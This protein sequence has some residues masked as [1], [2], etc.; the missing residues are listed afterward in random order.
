MNRRAL[1]RL[2][3]L[4]IL[5]NHS[6]V[7]NFEDINILKFVLLT[8]CTYAKAIGNTLYY[9]VRITK[10]TLVCDVV[11]LKHFVIEEKQWIYFWYIYVY[12]CMKFLLKNIQIL[13]FIHE[14]KDVQLILNVFNFLNN[15]A[16]CTSED[17]YFVA[18]YADYKYLF[19]F[20]RTTM[21]IGT[22]NEN[23][24]KFFTLVSAL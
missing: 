24:F 8:R 16:I 18:K 22:W 17:K 23:I 2:F 20:Y 7:S 14:S 19:S 13:L 21:Y 6:K 10:Y 5:Q 9:F 11:F 12:P 1:I 3:K 4:K 15:F